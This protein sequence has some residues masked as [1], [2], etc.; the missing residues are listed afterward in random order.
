MVIAAKPKP[1]QS[2]HHKKRVGQHQRQTKHY[3]KTYW[4]YLP[5]I[6]LTAFV[7]GILSRTD[8][9]TFASATSASRIEDWTNSGPWVTA[10]LVAVCVVA[11]TIVVIRHTVAWQRAV[12]KSEQFFIHHH[13]LDILLVGFVLAGYIVTRGA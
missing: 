5:M 10:V 4:P 3:I 9:T 2:I 6:A 13:S 1:R 12:V 7:N 8:T 11:I